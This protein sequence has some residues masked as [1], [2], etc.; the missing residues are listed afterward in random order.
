V[1]SLGALAFGVLVGHR[2]GAA[3]PA[4]HLDASAA[5]EVVAVAGDARAWLPSL[6][7]VPTDDCDAWVSIANLGTESAQAVLVAFGRQPGPKGCALALGATCTGVIAPGASWSLVGVQIPTGSASGVLLSASTRP[8][9]EA[10]PEMALDEEAT[11]D[12]VASWLCARVAEAIADDGCWAFVDLAKGW[13]P[14]GTVLGLPYEALSGMPLAATVHQRCY[15]MRPPFTTT[16]ATFPAV[17]D[18]DLGAAGGDGWQALAPAVHASADEARSLVVVQNAGVAPADAVVELIQDRAVV[19]TCPVEELVPGQAASVDVT[20]CA[21]DG[22]TGAARVRSAQP[23]AIVVETRHDDTRMTYA[24][25]PARL[26]AEEVGRPRPDRGA[27]YVAH[28]SKGADVET[29]VRLARL[30]DGDAPAAT[31]FVRLRDAAGTVIAARSIELAEGAHA[32]VA[33]PTGTLDGGGSLEV[34]PEQRGQGEVV[35]VA[36]QRRWSGERVI[37]AM[38]TPLDPR[39]TPGG[40]AALVLPLGA[41]DLACCGGGQGVAGEVSVTNLVDSEGT[42]DVLIAFADGIGLVDT[43]CATLGPRQT[44]TF[45][46]L[47]TPGLLYSSF[48]GSARVVATDWTHYGPPALAAGLTTRYGCACSEAVPGTE[49]GYFDDVPGDE[50]AHVAAV[51]VDPAGGLAAELARSTEPCAPDVGPLRPAAVPRVPGGAPA[52]SARHAGAVLALP[53]LDSANQD[54]VCVARLTVRNAG[55]EPS[56]VVVIAQGNAGLCPPDSASPLWVACAG[57]LAPGEARDLT[58]RTDLAAAAAHSGLALSLSTRRLSELGIALPGV[59][60]DPP[61]ADVV[62]ERLAGLAGDGAGYAAFRAALAQGGRWQGIPL[63]RALGADLTVDVARDCAFDPADRA[64]LV[65]ADGYAALGV[66]AAGA[67]FPP[68][69]PFAYAVPVVGFGESD[70]GASR[71]RRRTWLGIQNVGDR[72]ARLELWFRATGECAIIRNSAIDW[73]PP[74]QTYELDLAHSFS[75]FDTWSGSVVVRSNMPLAIVAEHVVEGAGPPSVRAVPAR[76]GFDPFDVD[77]DGW[78]TAADEARVAAAVGR[79]AGDPAWDDRDDLDGDGTV[80]EADRALVAMHRCDGASA[81]TRD[82][83]AFLPLARR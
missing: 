5:G 24:A 29:A 10:A 47:D 1:L 32:S 80:T 20:D 48:Q 66:A 18:V 25:S 19:A 57:E 78:V 6:N 58:T 49:P 68:E 54:E 16:T 75:T 46:L 41:R 51:R 81:P 26:G 44:A 3:H 11:D 65:P 71:E 2:T 23:M 37:A 77:L 9:R 64:R 69:G 50:L 43:V 34:V 28:V 63:D 14:G 73:L 59:D 21:P 8:L 40:E 72:C 7:L 52:R 17:T 15:S 45:D 27:G 82:H 56:R 4:P 61:L 31:W 79:T 60:G 83:R 39:A 67:P 33:F 70:A 42:V 35:G 62:C 22:F 38:A 30:G 13:R 55:D 36:E 76:A 53:V 74:D 12:V